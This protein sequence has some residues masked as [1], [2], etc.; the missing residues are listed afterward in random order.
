MPP[1]RD[2]VALESRPLAENRQAPASGPTSLSEDAGAENPHVSVVGAEGQ[3]RTAD[4]YI[5]RLHRP[6]RLRRYFMRLL[7]DSSLGLRTASF[8]AS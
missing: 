1:S 7:T 4:T 2:V 8:L 6:L 5:F 3:T